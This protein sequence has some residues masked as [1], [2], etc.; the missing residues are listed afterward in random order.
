MEEDHQLVLRTENALSEPRRPS[1][2]AD[3][4][5]ELI[6]GRKDLLCAHMYM[7]LHKCLNAGTCAWAP[8]R[9]DAPEG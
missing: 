1:S 3:A 4:H 2:P 8:L 9:Y 5:E 6:H 7:Q